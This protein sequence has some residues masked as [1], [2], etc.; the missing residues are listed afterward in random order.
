MLIEPN[1]INPL[2]FAFGL[3]KKEERGSLKF[4][5]QYLIQLGLEAQL[6]LRYFT[7]QGSVLPNKT[8]LALLPFVG[9]LETEFTFGFY[10]VAIFDVPA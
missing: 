6:C 8:P 3:L 5:P 9:A 7:S 2:M 4:T 10:H 1:S